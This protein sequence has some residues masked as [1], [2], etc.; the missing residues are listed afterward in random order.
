MEFELEPTASLEVYPTSEPDLFVSRSV[1]ICQEGYM[2]VR[3]SLE[4]RLSR[5]SVYN[6][7]ERCFVECGD[8]PSSLQTAIASAMCQMAE[9]GTLRWFW[10]SHKGVV[11]ANARRRAELSKALIANVSINANPWTS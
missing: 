10:F 8:C 1:Y 4:G 6:L 7:S 5:Y 9:S 2:Y 3:V 11:W